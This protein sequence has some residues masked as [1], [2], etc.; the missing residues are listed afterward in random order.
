MPSYRIQRTNEDILREMT[1]LLREVKDPRVA[2][3]MLTV[4]KTDTDSDLSTCKVYVS[5]LRGV[6]TAKQAVAVL[7]RA[8]F[9]RREL[10]QRLRLRHAPELIFIADD[11]LEHSAHISELLKTL[12]TGGNADAD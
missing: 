11:S 6:D 3:A 10:G 9:L 12:G 4:V 7:R 8:G 1:A 5:S 2:E